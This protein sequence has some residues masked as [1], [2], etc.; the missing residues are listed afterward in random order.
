MLFGL[1]NA[2]STFQDMM[3]HVLSSLL[4]VRVLAYM[5]DILV[6]T[7]TEEE[8]NQLV[9]EVLKRLQSNNL[10]LSPEKYAWKAHE[11]EFLG[12]IIRRD[13]IKM[14]KGKVDAVLIWR[15]PSSLTEVQAFLGFANFY[16]CFIQ[17]YSR[18]ARPLTELTKKESGKG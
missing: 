15:T 3:N 8:D 2:P 6:F 12:Y 1:T 10:A 17:N 18:V 5:D 9:R 14:A 11:V 16:R 4:D 13:G 7:K